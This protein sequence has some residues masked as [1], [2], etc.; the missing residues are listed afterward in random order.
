MLS[1]KSRFVTAA[2]SD[3][4]GFPGLILPQAPFRAR[5]QAA[6]GMVI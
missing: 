1:G 5:L 4:R 2:M 3:V 6:M